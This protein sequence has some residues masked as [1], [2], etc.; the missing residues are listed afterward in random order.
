MSMPF[1][2]QCDVS[3]VQ[4]AINCPEKDL[5]GKQ[6]TILITLLCT[7]LHSMSQSI[8]ISEAELSEIKLLQ[9]KFHETVF[10]LGELGVE[11]IELDRL[12]AEFVEKEKNL[13]EEWRNLQ[14]MEEAL[15][16]KIVQRYGEG[17]LNMQDGTFTPTVTKS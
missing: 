17:S 9:G 1:L 7:Y 15:L 3:M 14:K 10:K 13:K 4:L 5:P 2:R 16:D 8:K 11:K 12:V 6:N